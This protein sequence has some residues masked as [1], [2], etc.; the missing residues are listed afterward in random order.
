MEDLIS[1][2][3]IVL[4]ISFLFSE[5]FFRIKYPRVIGQIIAG[6][7]L[8]FPFFTILIGSSVIGQ[9]E[10]LA[11]LGIIFLLLLTGLQ[12]NLDKFQ[13]AEK[14]AIIIAMFSVLIPFVMGFVLIKMLG[15][16][17]FVAFTVGACLSL[18]AEGTKLKVLLDMKA[19]NTKLGT[20]MLGA[21]ILDDIFEV[22]FLSSI[23]FLGSKNPD[24]AALVA[25]PV[26]IIIFVAIVYATYKLFPMG[27]RMIEKEH[28]RVSTFSF[29][30][31]FG[32]IIAA[33]SKQLDLGP[34]IGA[35]IA[36]III[37]LA[38]HKKWEHYE[39]VKELQ[40]MTFSL[41]IPFFFVNIGLH[42][43]A[44]EM[45]QNVGLLIGVLS[46][47]TAG[48]LIGALVAT[49]L[50]SLSL[51]QTHLVGWGMNSRGLIE[52]VMADFAFRSGLI[53]SEVYG[54]IVVMAIITTLAFPIMMKHI[55]KKDRKILN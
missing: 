31:I 5:F 26:K 13:K 6:I 17:N 21:G 12:L 46:V 39:T 33:L 23:L 3:A 50:T 41:I 9:I 40:V 36:G 55:V 53:P 4:V 35:F 7:L 45:L 49:P 15:Y 29:V 10:F 27:M 42:F 24:P 18:T 43:P 32:I 8:S 28:S 48:K 20:I 51:K 52:L 44:T 47:A 34:V 11:E 37:H 2:I 19:L 1:G 54:A 25:I 22:L 38:E 30:L 14:D 16:D